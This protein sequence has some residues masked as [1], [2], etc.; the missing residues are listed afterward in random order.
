MSSQDQ[1]QEICEVVSEAARLEKAIQVVG[2]NSKSFYG[3]QSENTESLSIQ[4][5]CGIVDYEP[6]ELFI[7]ARGGTPLKEIEA[8]L[9]KH[10]QILPFEPPHYGKHATIGGSIACGFSG[11]RRPYSGAA[12]DC[13]LGTHII[14]GHGEY[15]QFGGQVMKNVAGYDVARSMCGALGTLGIIMQV[16]LRVLPKPTQEITIKVSNIASAQ[17]TIKVLQFAFLS[18]LAITASFAENNCV[19]LRIASSIQVAENIFRAY[20][21]EELAESENF[22]WSVKEHQ[23]EFFTG[24]ED[25]WRINVPNN[26]P[27]LLTEGKSIVEWNGGLRWLKT[28]QA[29]IH[30][31]AQQHQGHAV[32]FKTQ[33][34]TKERF[35]TLA[36]EVKQLHLNLKQA[37]DPK[38]ILNPGRMYSWC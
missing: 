35:P 22:W 14:N 5:H 15:L 23:H 27:P 34:E 29:D 7:T 36:T 19:Y 1:Q 10:N 26:T 17:D 33:R 38:G 20:E 8:E 4:Q 16:S 28:E 31:I 12:R 11:P 3:N 24:K 2:S 32:L 9:A 21:I 13:I 18:N 37:F 30:H 6:A 25:L